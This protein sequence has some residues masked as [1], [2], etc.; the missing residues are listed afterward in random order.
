MRAVRRGSRLPLLPLAIG[1]VCGFTGVLLVLLAIGL[2]LSPL[3]SR[4]RPL[5]IA[6]FG[7][8]Y[9][10]MELSVLARGALAWCVRIFDRDD[11]KWR[12]SNDRLLAGAL[13]SVLGAAERWLCFRVEVDV[14]GGEPQFPPGEPVLVLARH[15]GPGDSFALAHLLG[16]RY[17]R[18]VRI[19]A[20]DL[21]QID[22]AIDLLLNRRGSC[23]L[24]S[25]SSN[26]NN[27]GAHRLASCARTMRAG[28]A[29]LL[30]P[31]GENWTPRRRVRTIRRLWE[32]RRI[33]AVLAAETMSNVLPPRPAGV[34]AVLAARPG[35]E[36]VTCAHGG[37]DRIVTARQLWSEIPFRTPM[38]VR[39]WRASPPPAEEEAVAG[40]LTEE[41]RAVDEWIGEYRPE[42]ASPK[43]PNPVT[44]TQG[45]RD[46]RA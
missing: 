3:G 4:R 20:K 34:A 8:S 6:L 10:A 32:R 2:L 16:T 25:S 45:L 23:F 37:L 41:W 17:G 11:A 7:L 30:F 33:D 42:P 28:E 36:V 29:L 19:V 39:F 27:D 5:R 40:W 1:V 46:S 44:N 43:S 15:G 24:G 18:R 13:S 31:E 14:S 21:L 12:T 35:I 26:G 22:P 38:R 9:C